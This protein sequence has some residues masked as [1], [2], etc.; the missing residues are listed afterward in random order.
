MERVRSLQSS[1][2][3]LQRCVWATGGSA[4]ID[5]RVVTTKGEGGGQRKHGG[6][7]VTEVAIKIYGV[8]LPMPLVSSG[9]LMVS[10]TSLPLMLM[11]LSSFEMFESPPSRALRLARQDPRVGSIE[12]GKQVTSAYSITPLLKCE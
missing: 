7:F 11:V 8:N 5:V 10:V 9:N 6:S 2:S 1:S 4:V 12:E 3:A